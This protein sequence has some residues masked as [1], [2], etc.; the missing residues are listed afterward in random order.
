MTPVTDLR[1][2][3]GRL[4]AE[5]L[6]AS[7]TALVDNEAYMADLEAEIAQARYVY[8]MLAV[9]EIASLRAELAG[10]QVG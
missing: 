8:T 1:S 5:R 4:T 2:H 3:L 7:E 10:P 6:D 9:T